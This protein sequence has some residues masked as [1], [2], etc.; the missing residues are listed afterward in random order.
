MIQLKTLGCILSEPDDLEASKYSED[1]YKDYPEDHQNLVIHR[2]S[3][4]AFQ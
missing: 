1:A 4:Y 2:W 3:W